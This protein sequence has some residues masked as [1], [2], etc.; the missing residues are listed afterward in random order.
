MTA[1][2][3]DPALNPRSLSLPFF[4][5]GVVVV[6]FAGLRHTDIHMLRSL[7][8]TYLPR[9]VRHTYLLVATFNHKTESSRFEYILRERSLSSDG[10]ATMVRL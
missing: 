9:V 2:N 8:H 7:R 1:N 10:C 4:Q 6:H 3:V 5:N